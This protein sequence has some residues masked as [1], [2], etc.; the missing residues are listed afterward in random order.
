MFSHLLCAL[1]L[2]FP[3]IHFFKSLKSINN[4]TTLGGR[5]ERK[6]LGMTYACNNE[7]WPGGRQEALISFSTFDTQDFSVSKKQ[8]EIRDIHTVISLF[9]FTC[10]L[11]GKRLKS[12]SWAGN[13]S[14][15][16]DTNLNVNYWLS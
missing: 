15:I 3:I 10:F 5:E 14:F 7:I 13:F 2:H 6:H 11:G 8:R 9:F 12:C 4:L 16:F 1:Q